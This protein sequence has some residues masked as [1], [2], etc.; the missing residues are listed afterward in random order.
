M[1]RFLLGLIGL[2]Q[3]LARPLLG[4]RCRYF[5]SC[6]DFAREAIDQHGAIKGVLLSSHRICRCHPLSDGGL[7][8]VPAVFSLKQLWIPKG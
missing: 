7:D 1:K 6:S 4:Q 8:P 3:T 2:Y 5:P